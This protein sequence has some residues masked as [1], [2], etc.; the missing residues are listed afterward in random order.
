[1]NNRLHNKQGLAIQAINKGNLHQLCNKHNIV[2]NLSYKQNS[3]PMNNRTS[4]TN[5]NQVRTTGQDG[6]TLQVYNNTSNNK[7]LI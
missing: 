5:I 4:T 6:R 2:V 7:L 3:H 1:M